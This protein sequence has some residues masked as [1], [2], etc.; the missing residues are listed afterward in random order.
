MRGLRAVVMAFSMY[1]RIPMPPVDWTQESRAWTLCAFPLVGAVLG[2]TYLLWFS[3]SR[4]LEAGVILRGAVLTVLPLL[5]TGGIHMDGFC[6]T[7]DALASHRSRERKLEILS[8]PHIGAFAAMGCGTYLLAD[9]GLWCQIDTIAAREWP[10]LASLPVLSRC[11]SARAA[12]SEPNARGGGLLAGFTGGDVRSQKRFLLVLLGLLLLLMCGTA[13]GASALLCACL[14]AMGCRRI[15]RREFGGMTGDLAGWLLQ[16]S[17]LAGL[18]GFVL[19][20]Q[21]LGALLR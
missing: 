21:I 16:V 4:L 11:L 15:A 10:I 6:D 20:R 9:F 19:V 12:L 1:S 17:E 13:A 3:L 7:V 18:G 8:D 5:V 2:G 14:G